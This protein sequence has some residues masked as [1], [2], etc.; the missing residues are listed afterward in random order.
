MTETEYRS[1]WTKGTIAAAIILIPITVFT[2]EFTSRFGVHGSILGWFVPFVYF[3]LFA[4]L[5]AYV[6]PKLALSPQ[7]LVMLLIPT[8]MVA[9]KG[10]IIHGAPAYWES[11]MSWN[12]E[13][14]LPLAYGMNVEPSK[15]A[16]GS[17]VPPHLAP[18]DPVALN[19]WFVPGGE[20]V[21]GAWA[22]PVAFWIIWL[23]T[24]FGLM[25]FLAW[26][27][28]R[29]QWVEV[30]NLIFPMAVPYM[31]LIAGAEPTESGSRKF[32]LLDFTRVE[33]KLFW[34]ASIVG[35]LISFIPLLA[36][37]VAVVPTGGLWGEDDWITGEMAIGLA[38]SLGLP[39]AMFYAH[40]SIYEVIVSI[41]L[42]FD[43]LL[44]CLLSWIVFGLIYP[45]VGTA[46]GFLPYEYGGPESHHFFYGYRP[47]FPYVLWANIGLTLGIGIWC[48]WAV[49][50][51]FRILASSLTKKVEEDGISLTYISW[52]IVVTG[53][54]FLVMTAGSGMPFQLTLLLLVVYILFQVGL[55]RI[56]NE[57][58]PTCG[59]VPMWGGIAYFLYPAGLW[60]G[61]YPA[62]IPTTS[63]AAFK[64][65][66][67]NT[68]LINWNGRLATTNL[69]Y[70][71]MFGKVA[72]YTKTRLSDVFKMLFVSVL[73]AL[74]LAFVVDTWVTQ[75]MGGSL[76]T[77]APG[78]LNSRGVLSLDEWP[79]SGVSFELS[80]ATIFA[81]IIFSIACYMLRSRFPWFFLNPVG[82]HIGVW[83]MEYAWL[84]YGIIALAIKYVLLKVLG[85][86]K[87]SQWVWPMAAGACVGVGFPLIFLGFYEVFV[88]VIPRIGAMWVP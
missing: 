49:R 2:S 50:G 82:V 79:V 48:L 52:G 9:G 26:G 84:G 12:A 46:S 15:S 28:F 59:C 75:H 69:G 38:D 62:T 64:S 27:L 11:V 66:L 31:Y 45:I 40:L 86:R 74:P 85:G 67:F 1:G 33:T 34:G 63:E 83:A 76:A 53:I 87:F 68:R 72:D 43:V 13:T 35:F 44:T 78:N 88:Y 81:G 58:S 51:R 8:Y 54:L 4:Q 32:R 60:S 17:W 70:S 14:L 56:T 80:Y 47:P 21:W 19:S 7:Q 57:M 23:L 25:T 16:W 22:A 61:A 73:I 3:W 29:K 42:P 55:G 24:V 71:V 5:L 37:F 65:A 6:S 77:G 30:E 10:Y 39:G 20:I 36:E 18:T 41:L